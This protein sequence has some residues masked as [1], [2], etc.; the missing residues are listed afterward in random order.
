MGQGGSFT[1]A[2]VSA[3]KAFQSSHGLKPD[4]VAGPAT[5]AALNLPPEDIVQMLRVNMERWRWLPDDLGAD[6]VFV[7]IA[8]YRVDLVLG[9]ER[10]RSY[11]A[12]VGRNYFRTPVFSNRIRYLV[13]DPTWE[14]PPSIA[15]DEILPAIRRD[16]TYL[17]RLGF[18][19]LSGWGKTNSKWIRCR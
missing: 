5:V 13:L 12:V 4:G 7:N 11:A 16:P 19:V 6:H 1:P 8:D 17:Q 18:R 2:A 14:V 9:G 10:V 15:T 3:V